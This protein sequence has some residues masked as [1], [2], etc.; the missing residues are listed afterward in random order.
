[1]TRR[2]RHQEAVDRVLADDQ[3]DRHLITAGL[4]AGLVVQQTG[5]TRVTPEAV[6]DLAATMAVEPDLVSMLYA[7][8]MRLEPDSSTG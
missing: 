6:L 5:S 4:V 1:M 2:Q 3:A 7:L 8:A